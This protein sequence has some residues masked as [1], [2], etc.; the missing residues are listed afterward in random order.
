MQ[1]YVCKYI[2]VLQYPPV[3]CYI[4]SYWTWPSRTDVS[5]PINSIVDLSS[6]FCGYVYQRLIV[7]LCPSIYDTYRYLLSTDNH[8]LYIIAI[9]YYHYFTHT[10]P[11]HLMTILLS[12]YRN[13]DP[14]NLTNP[15]LGTHMQKPRSEFLV[16][17][18]ITNSQ[19][20][21]M[22]C[23]KHTLS[24]LICSEFGL[25]YVPLQNKSAVWLLAIGIFLEG[26]GEGLG[27]TPM[28]IPM[29]QHPTFWTNDQGTHRSTKPL[30]VWLNP[31]SS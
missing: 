7:L 2:T 20:W 30:G 27:A 11:W 1:F 18:I 25:S 22:R 19:Y 5:F 6:S 10:S 17:V 23:D 13:L 24:K 16:A 15:A 4:D 26:L 21:V 8:L 12:S 28:A 9:T 14:F 29:A 31:L 3:I